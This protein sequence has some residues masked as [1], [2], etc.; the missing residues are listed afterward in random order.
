MWKPAEGR[1]GSAALL[2]RG[3]RRIR[4]KNRKQRDPAE[5]GAPRP[6]GKTWLD[7]TK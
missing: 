1:R 3:K 2:G 6:G 4:L 5:V 7:A